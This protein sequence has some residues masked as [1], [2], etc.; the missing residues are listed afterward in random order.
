MNR[1]SDK[2]CFLTKEGKNA[3]EA[4][5]KLAYPSGFKHISIK[6]LTGLRSETVTKILNRLDS[7]KN[8]SAVSIESFG[9]FFR[10]L[11]NQKLT[12]AQ[13]QQYTRTYSGLNLLLENPSID[14]IYCKQIQE[15]NADRLKRTQQMA[16]LLC[17][18][19]YRDRESIFIDRVRDVYSQAISFSLSAPCK[20]TQK[21]LIYRLLRLANSIGSGMDLATI[22]TLD[23]SSP[24]LSIWNLSNICAE[25][26]RTRELGI[27]YQNPLQVIED[28]AAYNRDYRPVLIK[29]SG[30]QDELERDILINEFWQR[31]IEHIPIDSRSLSLRAKRSRLMMFLLE[32]NSLG[33]SPAPVS[34]RFFPLAAPEITINDITDWIIDPEVNKILEKH[35]KE[36]YINDFTEIK[37]PKWNCWQQDRNKLYESLDGLCKLFFVDYK[38][39]E[40]EQ[41]WNN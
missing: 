40:L 30:L 2:R 28:L 5:L 4:L 3:L 23:R 21:W 27:E 17:K 22:I 36:E 18:L 14:I 15:S 9:T 24:T 41:Y 34:D 26:A 1:G 10:I 39:T 8:I 35:R 33:L 16:E 29:V 11:Y 6:T 31:L 19:D 20:S 25:I 37:L 32:N 12:P 7:T 38:L 13:Q